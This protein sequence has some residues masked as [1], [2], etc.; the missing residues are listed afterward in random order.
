MQR[1]GFIFADDAIRLP[2]AIGLLHRN[3]GAEM[4]DVRGLLVRIDDDGL[5]Q[6]FLNVFNVACITAGL[7]L[8]KPLLEL[9]ITRG[10]HIIRVLTLRPRSDDFTVAVILFDECATHGSSKVYPVFRE[11]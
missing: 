9:A 3:V 6:A 2:F 11:R 4:D 5:L 8:R 7:R 10:R 1:I